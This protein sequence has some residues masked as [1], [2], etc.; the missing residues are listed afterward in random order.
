MAQAALRTASEL[1]QT[2]GGRDLNKELDRPSPTV[3]SCVPRKYEERDCGEFG[4]KQLVLA[5]YG[6]M[7][8]PAQTDVLLVSPLTPPRG[9]GPRSSARTSREVPRGLSD[10]ALPA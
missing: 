3:L 10:H 6:R 2:D 4:T 8:A 1:F 7:S 5:A 9:G